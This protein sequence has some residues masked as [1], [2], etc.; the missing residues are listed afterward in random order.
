[1]LNAEGEIVPIQ[2]NTIHSSV[3]AMA[4]QG[5]RVLAFAKKNVPTTKNS[6]DHGDIQNDLIFLGLQGMIDPPRSEA[7][8]AV[9]ACQEAGIQVKMIT[10]DHAVTAQAI[11]KRMGFNKNGEVMAFTGQQLAQMDNQQLK[12]AVEDGVVFA[13]VAPEQKLRIVEALQSKG[14]IVAMTG[15]GVNDAPALKQADIGIAMGGAGTEVA[16]EA[17]DMIL[18][19]DN[20]AS[21][22]A[23]VEEGRTVYRNLLKA[24]AFILPVNGGE[25]MTILISVLFAR[26]LPILSL[27]VLWLNMVNSIAMTVPLAFEPSHKRVMRQPPRNPRQPLLSGSLIKRIA[28]ISVFNWILIF[29]MFEWI[30]QTTANIDLGRTMA[31]QA[32]VAGRVFYLL[33][34]SKLGVIIIDTI[35]GVKHNISDASAIIIGIVATIVLQ[36]IFSQ[37][38][39]MNNLFSTA[40]LNLNQ[41]LICI[42]AGL[43]MILVAALVNRF[44]PLD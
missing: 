36:I 23:A 6:L 12:T 10:G 18:T 8:I 22:Q 32:L 35:R 41:W 33:S 38:S 5:L 9:Q 44:D 27:Q 4:Q 28:V 17:S 14:E 37:W 11:A 39:V 3:N 2:A 20:F 29:G 34:I 26:V 25:S 42:A 40:P 31:I 30:R 7:I 1:M 19:D 43:P 13:R 16:K 15:D 24:I 21:I